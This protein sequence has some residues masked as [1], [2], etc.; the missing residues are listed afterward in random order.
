MLVC[1]V[2]MFMCTLVLGVLFVHPH[3]TLNHPKTNPI[4]PLLLIPGW[5]GTALEFVSDD[6]E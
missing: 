4:R 6:G 5:G 2:K 1:G 3:L